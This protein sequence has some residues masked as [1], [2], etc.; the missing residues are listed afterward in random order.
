LATAAFYI[1]PLQTTST[2]TAAVGIDSYKFILSALVFFNRQEK[3]LGKNI[4]QA[5]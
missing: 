5:S 1:W 2:P 4:S 3:A